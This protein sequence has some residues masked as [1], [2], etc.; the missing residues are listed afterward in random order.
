VFLK[1]FEKPIKTRLINYLEENNLLPVSQYGFRQRLCAK[2]VLAYLTK[3]IYIYNYFDNHNKT[4]GI[5]LDL[6]KAFD[7]IS[8]AKRLNHCLASLDQHIQF[9]NL[10]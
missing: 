4:I 9:L 7:N 10:I 3:D 8:H 6:S 2:N 1:I 5:V